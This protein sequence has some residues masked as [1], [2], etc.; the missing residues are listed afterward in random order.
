MDPIPKRAMRLSRA[1]QAHHRL[2]DLP[3]ANALVPLRLNSRIISNRVEHLA[4]QAAMM[5]ST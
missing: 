2:R 4:R 5:K 1:V 3:S